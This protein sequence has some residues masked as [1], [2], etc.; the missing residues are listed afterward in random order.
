MQHRAFEGR[1][2]AGQGAWLPSM[3]IAFSRRTIQRDKEG[4][5]SREKRHDGGQTARIQCS[6]RFS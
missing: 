5:V 2:G 3:R 4:E 1:A 6:W